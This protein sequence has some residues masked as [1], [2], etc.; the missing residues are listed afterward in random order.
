MK[1]VDIIDHLIIT[2]PGQEN[3]VTVQHVNLKTNLEKE[4]H[5]ILP[6]CV[7]CLVLW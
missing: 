7:S 1:A 5:L 3:I 2:S 4:A 6:F